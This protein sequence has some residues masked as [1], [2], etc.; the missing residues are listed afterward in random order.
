MYSSLLTTYTL[1][2][3]ALPTVTYCNG[4]ELVKQYFEECFKNYHQHTGYDVMLH[5]AKASHQVSVHLL[6]RERTLLGM[7]SPQSPAVRASVVR[8]E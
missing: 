5:V 6:H 1:W 8:S 3:M 2:H 4:S 7:P